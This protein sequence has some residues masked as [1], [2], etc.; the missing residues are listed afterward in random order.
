MEEIEG[1]N[2]RM[3]EL[4][5]NKIL[6]VVLQNYGCHFYE[7]KGLKS[8][9]YLMYEKKDKNPFRFYTVLNSWPE[10]MKQMNL[11]VL[12]Y[13]KNT[14]TKFKRNIICNPLWLDFTPTFIHS[15]LKRILYVELRRIKRKCVFS[16]NFNT[17][18]TQIAV[19]KTYIKFNLNHINYSGLP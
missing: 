2:P 10:I 16:T 9:R 14:N 18:P 3:E 17:V 8:I 4:E 13:D 6:S 19:W 7:I 15:S 11:A 5:N 12:C 1:E